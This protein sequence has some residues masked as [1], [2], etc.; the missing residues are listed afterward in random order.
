MHDGEGTVAHPVGAS[1]DVV[2]AN[3]EIALHHHRDAPLDRALDELVHRDPLVRLLERGLDHA[4]AVDDALAA[5]AGHAVPA[6]AQVR[7]D[8][9]EL[10]AMLV[11]LARVVL[12]TYVGL[13]VGLKRF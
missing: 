2:E 8:R 1:P 12:R 11:L 7:D 9:L 6:Y 13:Q 10:S 5:I 3:R 4:L